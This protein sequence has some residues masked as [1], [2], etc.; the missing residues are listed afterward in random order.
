[1]GHFRPR[2]LLARSQELPENE[3]GESR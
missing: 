3:R 2:L 1:V